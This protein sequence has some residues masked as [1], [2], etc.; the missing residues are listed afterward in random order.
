MTDSPAFYPDGQPVSEQTRAALRR[1]AAWTRELAELVS[2]PEERLEL[3]EFAELSDPDPRQA[4]VADAALQRA[5]SAG[6]IPGR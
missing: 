5:K 3:L 6:V 1:V 2:D 4:E